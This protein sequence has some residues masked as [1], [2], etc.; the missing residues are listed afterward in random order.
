MK[1]L[2]G[3]VSTLLVL[4]LGVYV[5]LKMWGISMFDEVYLA[6]VFKTIGVLVLISILL[7]LLFAFF[8]KDPHKGYDRNKGVVAHPKK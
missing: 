3:T 1:Y 5:V 2:I 6:L 8:F 7:T 4:L